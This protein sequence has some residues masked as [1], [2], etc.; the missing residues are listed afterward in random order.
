MAQCFSSFFEKALVKRVMRRTP[1]RIDRLSNA[2]RRDDD[3]RKRTDRHQERTDHPSED[4]ILRTLDVLARRHVLHESLEP[5]QPLYLLCHEPT[6]A[7]RGVPLRI[8]E[9]SMRFTA[10][11]SA[12]ISV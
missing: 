11:S 3:G 6:P 9:A 4:A 12:G 8:R 1:M 7:M 10:A 5:R 2:C